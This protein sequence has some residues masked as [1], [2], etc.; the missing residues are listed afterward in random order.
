MSKAWSGAHTGADSEEQ[1]EREQGEGGGAINGR[2]HN[3]PGEKEFHAWTLRTGHSREAGE[4][5]KGFKSSGSRLVVLERHN[6]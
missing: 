5:W 2:K 4:L 3:D 1:T 6:F